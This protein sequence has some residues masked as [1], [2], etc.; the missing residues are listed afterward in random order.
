MIRIIH[1]LICILLIS[2]A[3]ISQ[4]LSIK[5]LKVYSST[6]TSFPI[7]TPFEDDNQKLTIEFDVDSDVLPSMNIVFRYCDRNWQ[8]YENIFLQNNGKNIEYDLDFDILPFTCQDARY[9]FKGVFPNN[10]NYVDFPFS[11]KWM[12][13]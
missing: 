9:H 1:L 10:E 4:E 11:G 12:F 3:G 7:L 6:E 13:F 5:S 2:A 8:P